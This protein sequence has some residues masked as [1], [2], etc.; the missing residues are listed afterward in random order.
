MLRDLR[1]WAR[2]LALGTLLTPATQAQRLKW[3]PTSPSPGT[4]RYGLHI[5]NFAGIIGHDGDLPGFQSFMGYVPARD[6]TIVVLANVYP[7]LDCR[8]PADEIV[9][10]IAGRLKLFGP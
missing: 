5:T 2:A 4:P 10:L 9:K 8:G 6:A 1:I 7:D 3:I